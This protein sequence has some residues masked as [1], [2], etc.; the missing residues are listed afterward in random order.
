MPSN[1]LQ[2]SLIAEIHFRLCIMK[3]KCKNR[4]NYDKLDK[5]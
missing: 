4:G 2:P 1:M 5:I 3:I